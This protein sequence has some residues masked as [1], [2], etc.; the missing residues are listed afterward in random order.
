M[1]QHIFFAGKSVL[2]V[3]DDLLTAERLRKQLKALGFE[4]VLMALDLA[5]AYSFVETC[6]ID[7]ALLDVKLQDGE[8]SFEL[9]LSLSNDNVP[10]VFFSG[11]TAETVAKIIKGREFMEKPVSLPR[12]K[13]ALMRAILKATPVERAVTRKKMAGQEARQ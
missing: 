13:A 2:L 4:Q 5:D 3:E 8:T 1:S 11:Y 9:G 6:A 7:V 10:V 12:L